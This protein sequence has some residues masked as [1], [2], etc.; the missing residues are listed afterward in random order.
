MLDTGI[1]NEADYSALAGPL[2]IT[3]SPFIP[4]IALIVVLSIITLPFVYYL[5][6][7]GRGYELGVL[8]ALGLSKLGA[9]LHLV[10]E[11]VTLVCMS[12]IV[13][14]SVSAGIYSRFAHSML[15]LNS[16]EDS[17]YAIT[18]ETGEIAQNI[19]INLYALVFILV[20]A[21]V[22]IVISLLVQNIIIAKSEPLELIRAYK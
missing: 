22:I 15:S 11:N 10:A 16:I 20:F 21:L 8:R 14:F 9:W 7:V 18:G 12:L 3:I 17:L 6:C 2:T 5:F 4:L 13:T 19:S 1:I